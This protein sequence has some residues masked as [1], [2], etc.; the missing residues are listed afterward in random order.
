MQHLN[1]GFHTQGQ[2]M[3]LTTTFITTKLDVT[4]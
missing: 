2:N 4:T 1:N 3:A